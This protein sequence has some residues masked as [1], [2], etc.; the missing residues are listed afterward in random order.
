[1]AFEKVG[2]IFKIVKKFGQ[3]AKSENGFRRK[4]RVSEWLGCV[5]GALS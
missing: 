3:L 5:N 2:R 4:I 1:L